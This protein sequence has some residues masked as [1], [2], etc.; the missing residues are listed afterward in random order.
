MGGESAAPQPTGGDEGATAF[1]FESTDSVE[2]EKPDIGPARGALVSTIGAVTSTASLVRPE[3]IS[4]TNE[5]KPTQMAE[6][7]I[8]YGGRGQLTD[9]QQAR[10]GQQLYDIV[11]PF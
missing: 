2:P 3:D 1:D 9:V 4:A 10:Y 6:A 7:R 11:F 8:S 5:V